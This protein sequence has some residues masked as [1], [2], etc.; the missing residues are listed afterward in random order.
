MNL[1]NDETDRTIERFKAQLVAFERFKAQLVAKGYTQR[2]G[3]DFLYAYSQLTKI[4]MIRVLFAI[5]SMHSLLIHQMDVK[6]NHKRWFGWRDLYG[7]I[8]RWVTL[9]QEH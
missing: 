4:T 3:E 8:P 5:A 1:T 2:S 7:P 6:C 9:G